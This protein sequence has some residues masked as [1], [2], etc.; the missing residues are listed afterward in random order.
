MNNKY[1]VTIG[2]EIHL[3]L[4]TKAKMFSNSPNLR[5]EANQF[6]NLFDLAYLGTLPK[7]NKEAVKKAIILAKALKMQISPILAFDRKNYFYPDLPKGF[8]IS[9]QFHPIG[10]NGIL[11]VGD[12]NVEIE[13]IHLEEDTAKQ[14]HKDNQTFFDYNRCGVPLIEIVT[15]PVISSSKLAAKYVDEIKKLALFL[16][17]S[18]AKLE[19][20]SLR[21]DINISVRPE[22]QVEFN[23][24]VE[25]KNINSISNIQKAAELEIQEQIYAYENGIKVKQVTKKFNDVIARNQILRLK[26]DAIDYKYFPEPNLPY[27]ELKPNFVDKIQVP[28]TPSQIEKMLKKEGVSTFYINQILN[29]FNYWTYL[30]NSNPDNWSLSVKLFFSEIVPIINKL[31]FE[32]LAI[33]FDFFGKI[34]QKHFNKELSNSEIRKII[35]IKQTNKQFNLNDILSKIKEKKLSEA[36]I[37]NLLKEVVSEEFAQIEKNRQDKSKLFK[38]LIGK[39]M[40]KTKGNAEPIKVNQVLKEWLDSFN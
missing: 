25:I 38:F 20:G 36:A 31:G 33:E 3:E 27:I 16:G 10:K 1:L 35:E 37:K 30:N 19:N 13:R 28:L 24:K 34:I 21:A 32:N 7:I 18:D 8:Q 9:Q 5:G 14:I 26:T 12:F 2:I 39:L 4:N 22:N 40:Q 23:P 17:I 29:N 6:F 11:K 15:R